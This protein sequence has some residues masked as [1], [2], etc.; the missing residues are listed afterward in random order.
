M[1]Y[2]MAKV[3]REFTGQNINPFP[4]DTG[5]ECSTSR[6]HRLS[7]ICEIDPLLERPRYRVHDIDLRLASI[8]HI[9]TFRQ[10]RVIR[11]P[12]RTLLAR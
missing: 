10:T 4:I 9:C 6:L 1:M 7:T 8:H 12:A 3:K 2:R 5:I 11:H